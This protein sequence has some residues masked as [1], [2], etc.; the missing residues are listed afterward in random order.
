MDIWHFGIKPLSSSTYHCPNM[1]D[2]RYSWP[3][4][5]VNCLS[6]LS[7]SRLTESS[8]VQPYK[9]KGKNVKTVYL[10]TLFYG[11]TEEVISE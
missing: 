11:T 6:H 5:I 2:I 9:Y 3:K 4:Y 8:P 10:F 7:L 1:H